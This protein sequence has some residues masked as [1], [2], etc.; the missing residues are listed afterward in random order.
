MDID[1][2]SATGAAIGLFIVLALLTIAVLLP[3]RMRFSLSAR[4]I[5]A[6]LDSRRAADPV[7][8]EEAYREVALRYEAMYDF[9]AAR[10]RPL[11]WA[12]R[13]AIVCLVADV[14]LWIVVLERGTP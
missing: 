13:A 5:V 11:F 10:I 12:F 3:Y 7:G 2:W 9:N 1:V 14:A 6:I 8:A 4:S